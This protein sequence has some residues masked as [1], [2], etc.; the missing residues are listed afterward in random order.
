MKGPRHFVFVSVVLLMPLVA[1]H[2]LPPEKVTLSTS[3]ECP[4]TKDWQR[5]SVDGYFGNYSDARIDVNPGYEGNHP[6]GYFPFSAAP[7]IR[8]EFR[9]ALVWSNQGANGPD[10]AGRMDQGADDKWRIYDNQSREIGVNERVRITG[11]MIEPCVV[12]VD[13]IERS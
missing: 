4:K 5:I 12:K 11:V 10:K 9:A 3:G 2:L 13:S 1:C 8:T 7:A 6:Y